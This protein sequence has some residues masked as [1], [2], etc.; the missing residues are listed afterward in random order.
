MEFIPGDIFDTTKGKP[1]NELR[2]FSSKR[3][4]CSVYVHNTRQY[5]I[6]ILGNHTGIPTDFNSNDNTNDI[7]AFLQYCA[8]SKIFNT[9]PFIKDALPVIIRDSQYMIAM[10]LPYY[11]NSSLI[12]NLYKLS[13]NEFQWQVAMTAAFAIRAVHNCSKIFYDL[14]PNNILLDEN[15]NPIIDGAGDMRSV[16]T[17]E[18][19]KLYLAPE[20]YK[21]NDQ[22]IQINK[23]SQMSDIYSLGK[24]LYL[25]FKNQNRE[26]LKNPNNFDDTNELD[27]LI[28]AMI[29]NEPKKRPGINFVWKRLLEMVP[30]NIDFKKIDFKNPTKLKALCGHPV[31][32]SLKQDLYFQDFKKLSADKKDNFSKEGQRRAAL[33]YLFN[34]DISQRSITRGL[35]LLSFR[36]TKSGVAEAK[37]FNEFILSNPFFEFSPLYT[38]KTEPKWFMPTQEFLSKTFDQIKEEEKQYYVDAV[39]IWNVVIVLKRDE[40]S[41]KLMKKIEEI[42]NQNQYISAEEIEIIKGRHNNEPLSFDA[43]FINEQQKL[44]MLLIKYMPL[45]QIITLDYQF[46]VPN[47]S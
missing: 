23:Y 10:R 29:N 14:K 41:Q 8:F 15:F 13:D 18:D 46:K 33:S 37:C 22:K 28:K 2:S 21:E 16:I 24:I 42:E 11:S 36:T 25:V 26:N 12:P 3:A 39:D 47:D 38:D 7:N 19:D 27:K 40:N 32:S 20:L 31:D 43:Q 5:F 17:S 45:D 6:K 34:S 30:Q 35:L 1:N 44:N 4:S 9:E